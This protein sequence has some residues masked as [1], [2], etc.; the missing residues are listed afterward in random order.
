[1]KGNKLGK[2]LLS[3]WEL[4]LLEQNWVP[5]FKVYGSVATLVGPDQ[6]RKVSHFD[7]CWEIYLLFRESIGYKNPLW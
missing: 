3:M 5:E 6:G 2:K 7:P 1:M 4:E